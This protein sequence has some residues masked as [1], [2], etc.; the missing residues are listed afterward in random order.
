[1]LLAGGRGGPDALTP[2]ASGQATRALGE[3]AVDHHT[4][5]GLLGDI[6]SRDYARGGHKAEVRR[7]VFA[8]ALNEILHLAARRSVA[9]TSQHG[10]PGSFQLPLE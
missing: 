4:T 1:M 7:R 6:V 8:E 2:L 10:V 3:P 9:T 5:E